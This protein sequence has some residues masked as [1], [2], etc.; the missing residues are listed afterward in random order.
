[1]TSVAS[2]MKLKSLYVSRSLLTGIGI[3]LVIYA[4]FSTILLCITPRGFHGGHGF[5]R[6]ILSITL[7][8]LCGIG[9]L[10]PQQMA[11][12]ISSLLL[13]GAG[14][15]IFWIDAYRWKN[16]KIYCLFIAPLLLALW[17]RKGLSDFAL[18]RLPSAH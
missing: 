2:S 12:L 5:V 14:V 18:R 15:L 3:L 13:V 11:K 6:P 4:V 8:W 17:L 9:L 7:P 1:M 10:L 16:L